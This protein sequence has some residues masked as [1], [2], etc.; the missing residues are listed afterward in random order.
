MDQNRILLDRVPAWTTWGTISALADHERYLGH[1]EKTRQGWLAFD[2]THLND[3][4]NGFRELG[5]FRAAAA[6]REAVEESTQPDPIG[7]LRY[8]RGYEA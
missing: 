8:L 1:V 4:G 5:L 7:M 2:A 3:E 6:A